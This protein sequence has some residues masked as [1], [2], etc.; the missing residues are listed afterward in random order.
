MEDQRVLWKPLPRAKLSGAVRLHPPPSGIRP[1]A[2]NTGIDAGRRFA[3]IMAAPDNR[4]WSYESF[5]LSSYAFTYM[6]AAPPR[7]FFY[8]FK[9][10]GPRTV[11]R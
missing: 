6:K 3:S 1:N 11:K 5:R 8:F 10:A 7:A 4:A 2:N 9:S